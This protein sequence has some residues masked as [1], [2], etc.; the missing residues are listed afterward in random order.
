MSNKRDDMD[1]MQYFDGELGESA[2]DAVA[3]QLADDGESRRKVEALG[4]MSDVMRTHLELAA[5]DASDGFA[6]MWDRIE[7]G[8]KANGA[9]GVA[10]SPGTTAKRPAARAAAHKEQSGF[11]SGLKAWLDKYRGHVLTGAVTAAAVAVLALVV[12]PQGERVVV[13]TVEVPAPVNN[14]PRNNVMVSTPPSVEH[15]DVVDGT[16]TV[17]ID[18]KD[19]DSSAAVI[20]VTRDDVVE[21]PI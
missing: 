17:M 10:E 21:G 12:R 13:R 5:D 2:S 14:P 15:L 18:K 8:I 6:G 3:S 9:N 7:R 19:K 16:G 20:W 1:L 4:Q 11:L